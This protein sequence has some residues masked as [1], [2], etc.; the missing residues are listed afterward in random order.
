[1]NT[2]KRRLHNP[3]STATT[4]STQIIDPRTVKKL[5]RV[6]LYLLIHLVLDLPHLLLHLLLHL[7]H[8]SYCRDFCICHDFCSW[9]GHHH[10]LFFNFFLFGMHLIPLN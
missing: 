9:F 5:K 4:V 7:L 3:N 8:F 1:M 2:K 6:V 10:F